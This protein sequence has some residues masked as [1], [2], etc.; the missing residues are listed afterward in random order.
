MKLQSGWETRN[1][2]TKCIAEFHPQ[3]PY[4]FAV[5]IGSTGHRFFIYVIKRNAYRDHHDLE[6]V[7]C[8]RSGGMFAEKKDKNKY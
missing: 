8:H 6:I 7:K 2:N 5:E 1:K 3:E 4:G